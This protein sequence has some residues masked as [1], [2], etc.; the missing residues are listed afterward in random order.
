MKKLV[1]LLAAGIL[2]ACQASKEYPE[3][4]RLEG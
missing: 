1:F 3:V 2:A 4:I